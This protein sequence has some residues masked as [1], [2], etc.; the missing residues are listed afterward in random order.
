VPI[1]SSAAEAHTADLS[2]LEGADAV[3]RLATGQS[4]PLRYS[5]RRAIL[6][7]GEA[8]IPPVFLSAGHAKLSRVSVGDSFP[9]LRLP[10]LGGAKTDLNTLRGR[11]ATVVLFWSADRWMARTALTDMQR[12]IANQ[13]EAGQ[14]AVVGV[15]VRQP[16]GAV[17]AALNQAQAIFPQLLDSDGQ[18]FSRLG[19]VALPRI[20]VLDPAGKIVWFDIEYSEGTRRELWRTL[21]VL[22]K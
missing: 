6:P 9:A 5:V 18:S 16:A 17:Q 21:Q 14:I 7:T 11:Q 8:T 3:D 12:D 10:R 4:A 20:Y 22:T 2:V 1:A 13:F 15:A 19:S